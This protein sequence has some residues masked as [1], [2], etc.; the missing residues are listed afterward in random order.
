MMAGA[1]TPFQILNLSYAVMSGEMLIHDAHLVHADYQVSGKGAY[2]IQ[3][4][5]VDSSMQL[6]FSKSISA[7][8]VHKIREMEFLS[9]R[10]GQVM[11]PFRYSG[12][13]PNASVQPDLQYVTNKLLQVGAEQ[14]LS[15]GLEKLA[16]FLEPKK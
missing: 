11:I 4:Q 8:L 9:D 10:N 15:R 14:F 5:R 7:Y 12:I 16:K 13:L 1:D 2:G 6:V 3:G